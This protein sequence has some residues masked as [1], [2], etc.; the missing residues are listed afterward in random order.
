VAPFHTFD[1]PGS[2]ASELGASMRSNDQP[3]STASAA[4]GRGAAASETV[5]RGA[6]ASE[7]VGRGAAASETVV[8]AYGG[9]DLAVRTRLGAGDVFGATT[10]A[11]RSYGPE[12]FG[13][14]VGVL[15]DGDA[16][17]DVYGFVNDAILRE[18]GAFPWSCPL[19]TWMYAVARAELALHRGRRK[20][21]L[22]PPQLGGS[23]PDPTSTVSRRPTNMRSKI[24]LLR[25]CLR[26]EDRELLI[27]RVD[28]S[29]DWRELALTALG[30][31]AS[32]LEIERE[33]AVH[34]TR[35]ERVRNQ[36]AESAR[37]QRLL[38]PE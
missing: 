3:P 38:G 27:L 13:F 16:A 36:L 12:I 8:R 19:R 1:G 34:R 6:A 33:A 26:E 24:A 21:P 30:P 35:F 7:T 31:K 22:R 15:G 37:E 5:G 11:I 10:D 29:F 23:M 17:R 2:I 14:L 25:A 28:R 20:Q 18:L 4:V 32:A 9:V